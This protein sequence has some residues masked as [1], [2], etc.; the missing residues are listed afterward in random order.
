M[1][2]TSTSKTKQSEQKRVAIEQKRVTIE[3]KCNVDRKSIL[4]KDQSLQ[5]PNRSRVIQLLWNVYYS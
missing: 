4:I 1:W 3:Q 2:E 5:Q